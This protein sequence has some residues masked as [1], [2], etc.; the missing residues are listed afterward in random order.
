M[1][2]PVPSNPDSGVSVSSDLHLLRAGLLSLHSAEVTS[3]YFRAAALTE[4]RARRDDGAA[5]SAVL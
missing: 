4:F 5:F 3:L 1:V 2:F